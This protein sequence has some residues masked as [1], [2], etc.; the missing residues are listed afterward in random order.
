MPITNMAMGRT[1][2]V[3]RPSAVV[4]DNLA[5]ATPGI[6]IPPYAAPNASKVLVEFAAP[7]TG[8]VTLSGVDPEG[9]AYV[10]ALALTGTRLGQT[11]GRFRALQ[12]VLV[13]TADPVTVRLVGDGG[14]RVAINRTM[15]E[16]LEARIDRTTVNWFNGDAG[17]VP[18]EQG[19]PHL[20]F[21]D[22]WDY[23]PKEG[24]LAVDL[25]TGT[26]YRMQGFVDEDLM[27]LRRH[28]EIP[29]KIDNAAFVALP[30]PAS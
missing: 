28:Y 20:L 13:S 16:G 15:I 6:A 4:V 2:R 26:I 1:F 29:V 17:E 21:D 7:F 9:A 24:D 3:L 18:R 27:S 10:E 5:A 30:P 25:R 19:G 8:T 14:E 11:F 12:G 22:V 23:E